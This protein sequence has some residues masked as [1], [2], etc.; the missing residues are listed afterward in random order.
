[1]SASFSDLLFQDVFTLILS[2]G[3][4]VAVVSIAHTNKRCKELVEL[5]NSREVRVSSPSLYFYSQLLSDGKEDIFRWMSDM[6][7]KEIYP[8]VPFLLAKACLYGKLVIVQAFA[9]F[10]S[11]LLVSDD[12]YQRSNAS[13][14]M[15]PLLLAIRGGHLPI[16][17]F[18]KKFCSETKTEAIA[19][20]KDCALVAAKWGHLHILKWLRRNGKGSGW[21]SYKCLFNAYLY[22]GE[23]YKKRE[24]VNYLSKNGGDGKKTKADTDGAA[25]YVILSVANRC[26]DCSF[27][28]RKDKILETLAL[29]QESGHTTDCYLRVISSMTEETEKNSLFSIEEMGIEH[30]PELGHLD[31][32]PED[33]HVYFSSTSHVLSIGAKLSILSG[34]SVGIYQLCLSA[35]RGEFL[36]RENTVN[37]SAV[38]KEPYPSRTS[39]DDLIEACAVSR[40]YGLMKWLLSLPSSCDFRVT[41]EQL[42]ISVWSD[43]SF[44]NFKQIVSYCFQDLLRERTREDFCDLLKDHNLSAEKVS[45]L[46]SHKS[47]SLITGKRKGGTVL[48]MINTLYYRKMDDALTILENMYSKDFLFDGHFLSWRDLAFACTKRSRQKVAMAARKW[49]ED[50]AIEAHN[51]SALICKT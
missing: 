16:L 36:P 28:M 1:M 14:Y 38:V 42:H 8:I 19:L 5:T 25:A 35:Q 7:P 47:I 21:N 32:S 22:I 15:S 6:A 27:P 45:C 12:N 13:S 34:N 50:K 51:N 37:S 43:L 11:D 26:K 31:F 4:S 20:F 2:F 49:I 24:L 46:L 9:R 40:N 3:D 30:I 41:Y 29:M 23:T 39:T 33:P 17:Q 44:S 10:L 48:S 18:L